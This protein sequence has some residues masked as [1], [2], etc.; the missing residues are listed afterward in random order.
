MVVN[1]TAKAVGPVLDVGW[2]LYLEMAFYLLFAAAMVLPREW[3]MWL[4]VGVLCLVGPVAALGPGNPLASFYAHPGLLNFAG[5]M[6]IAW[7]RFRLPAWTM[8]LGFALMAWFANTSSPNYTLAVTVP[9]L[10][11]I[12]GALGAE[13]KLPSPDSRPM[14]FLATL[15]DASFAIYLMHYATFNLLVAPLAGYPAKALVIIPL[16]TGL[17]TLVGIMVHRHIEQPLTRLLGGK[18]KRQATSPLPA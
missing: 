14:M 15:G 11:I 1:D 2:T 13:S 4:T 5:G 9:A 7:T 17:A 18:V 3:A 8:P 10:L 16:A 6:V 12:G